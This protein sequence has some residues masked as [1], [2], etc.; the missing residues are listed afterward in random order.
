VIVKYFGNGIYFKVRTRTEVASKG[1]MYVSHKTQNDVTYWKCEEHLKC[2]SC[3]LSETEEDS[4]MR[5]PIKHSHF[6]S[7]DLQT[8]AHNLRFKWL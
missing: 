4:F 5:A 1:F 6:V 8:T 3:V 7:S 2:K